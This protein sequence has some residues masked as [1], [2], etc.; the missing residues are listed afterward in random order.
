MGEM[1]FIVTLFLLLL[2]HLHLRSS[3]IRSRRLGTPALKNRNLRNLRNLVF[4]Q[5]PNSQR[6]W[7]RGRM[8]GGEG[9]SSGEMGAGRQM[10]LQEAGERETRAAA[11]QTLQHSGDSRGCRGDGRTARDMCGSSSH[12]AAVAAEI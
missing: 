12:A 7:G 3:G 9:A 1:V 2:H 8:W 11:G 6:A 4:L 5:L 10:V